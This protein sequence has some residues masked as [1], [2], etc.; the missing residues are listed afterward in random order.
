M[1]GVET[2]MRFET[3]AALAIGVLLPVLETYRRGLGH[4]AVEFSSMFED[5][6]AGALLLS[7]GWASLRRHASECAMLLLAWAWVTAG[8]EAAGVQANLN[9]LPLPMTTSCDTVPTGLRMLSRYRSTISS[10]NSTATSS[11]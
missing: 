9:T 4:W 1:T 2:L 7:A 10:R 5:Y 11:S 3:V 8:R 6:L